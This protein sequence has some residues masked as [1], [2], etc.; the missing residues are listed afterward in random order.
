MNRQKSLLFRDSRNDSLPYERCMK[1]G[2]ES[3]SDVELLAVLLRTGT[4]ERD[5]L[6]LSTD[7]LS[8]DYLHDGIS[9]LLHM[10]YEELLGIKGIGKVKA[11]QIICLLEMCKR[12][13]RSTAGSDN[14]I[15]SNPETIASY[16]NSELRFLEREKLKLVFLDQRKRLISDMNMTTGTINS[17]LVN[18]REILIES[19]RRRAVG[20]VILHNH[21]GGISDPSVEDIEITDKLKE[22]CNAIG[23]KLFDHIIIGESDY[24]SFSERNII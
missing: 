14:P 16:Y 8:R 4:K 13:W 24:Y 15:F 10:T 21:P 5:V 12:I 1:S 20:I 22:G 9:A 2:P 18:V 6:S 19:L 7:I 3:L 23:I 17:S 11:T